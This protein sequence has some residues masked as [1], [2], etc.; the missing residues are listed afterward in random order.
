V[1][2]EH[3][4]RRLFAAHAKK[5]LQNDDHEIHGREIVIQQQTLNSG[6]GARI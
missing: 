2:F 6:G 5:A 4:A 1:H 3:D